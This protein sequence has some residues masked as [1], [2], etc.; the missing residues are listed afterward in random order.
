MQLNPNH[1]T[2]KTDDANVNEIRSVAAPMQFES[3]RLNDLD[4]KVN[5]ARRVA[6]PTPPIAFYIA[7]TLVAVGTFLI[8]PFAESFHAFLMFFSFAFGPLVLAMLP[9]WLWRNFMSQLILIFAAIAYAAWFLLIYLLVRNARDAMAVVLF[10][11]IGLIASPFLL[12]ICGISLT[13][14]LWRSRD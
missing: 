10:S 6:D 1:P 12:V 13:F 2:T 7:A 3:D 11:Y 5:N 8:L 14:H 4:R 9:M